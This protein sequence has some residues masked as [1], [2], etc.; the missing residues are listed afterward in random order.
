MQGADKNKPHQSGRRNLRYNPVRVV[1]IAEVLARI[2]YSRDSFSGAILI[3]NNARIQTDVLF[4]FLK[5][6]FCRYMI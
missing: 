3:L 4:L 1:A 2:I 5:S 6:Y